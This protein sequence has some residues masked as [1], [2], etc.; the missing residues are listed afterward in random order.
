MP[1]L[2]K[3]PAVLAARLVFAAAS[4]VVAYGVFAPSGS[5]PSLMPWDKAEHFTAFFGLTFLG[6]F[7]FPRLPPW[8]LALLMS[9]TGAS[10]EIIQ[11]LPF[12]HRD[13]DV[14]DWVAD[15]LG[16][17]AALAPLAALRWRQWLRN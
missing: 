16:V 9:I 6:L 15:S 11:A 14:V 5:G 10:I 17:A 4:L 2:S 7:A 1:G 8:W 12:V 13:C 3:T